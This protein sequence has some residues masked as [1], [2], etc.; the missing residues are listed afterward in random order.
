[1]CLAELSLLRNRILASLAG[2]S[3]RPARYTAYLF[4]VAAVLHRDGSLEPYWSLVWLQMRVMSS[5]AYSARGFCL[6]RVPQAATVKYRGSGPQAHSWKAASW[7]SG[8]R[9]ARGQPKPAMPAS[10]WCCRSNRLWEASGCK[11]VGYK[12]PH[13][14]H[15]RWWERCEVAYSRAAQVWAFRC[16]DAAT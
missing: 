10:K 3:V 11:V 6:Q 2:S 14:Q 12:T 8:T 1:M 16:A 13:R 9:H 5:W 15:L 4:G 7:P